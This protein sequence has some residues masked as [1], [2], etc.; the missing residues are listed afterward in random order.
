[1]AV[2]LF[3]LYREYPQIKTFAALPREHDIAVSFTKQ[4]KKRKKKIF[5]NRVNR[6]GQNHVL[7]GIACVLPARLKRQNLK[8]CVLY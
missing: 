6:Q 2:C 5:T 7:R 3:A 4:K 1:M 8:I